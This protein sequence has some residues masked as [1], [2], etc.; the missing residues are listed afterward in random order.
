MFSPSDIEFI[1]SRGTTEESVARQ[2][3]RFLQGAAHVTLD[4]PA[5]VGDGIVR[6]AG[7]EKARLAA[8]LD[9]AAEAGRCLAFVPASGAASRMFRDWHAAFH[10][11]GVASRQ[12]RA[13]PFT[14][15]CARPCRKPAAAWRK[16]GPRAGSARFSTSS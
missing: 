4:R 5:T 12:G 2:I 7:D 11:G 6:L 3:D 16:P 9:G 8:L 1:R 10:R 14:G 13:M 15:T